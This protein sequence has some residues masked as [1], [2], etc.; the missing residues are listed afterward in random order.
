MAEEERARTDGNG[1]SGVH[2]ALEQIGRAA[3]AVARE[4]GTRR[5]L[6]VGALGAALVV[7]AAVL[8][9]ASAL[10]IPLIV[11]GAGMVVIGSLGPRLS[12]QMS[13]E[14]GASGARL[15]LQAGVAAPGSD[16]VEVAA[17]VAEVLVPGEAPRV[18]ESTGETIEVEVGEL[19]ALLRVA[20]TEGAGVLGEHPHP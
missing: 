14:W 6:R 9:E 11:L 5:G 3:S 20:G 13:L 8:G 4:L 7:I 10:T 19:E 1:A 2:M 18:I 17:P 12:G 16:A 15:N